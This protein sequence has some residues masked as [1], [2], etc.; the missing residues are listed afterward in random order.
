MTVQTKTVTAEELLNMPDDGTRRE[1]VRGELRET[2]PAGD[3]H[4][5]LALEIAAELRNHVKANKLGRTYT[6]ETGFKISSDPD[7]VRAPDAAFVGQ[8]RVEAA[9][10]ISGFRSG[11]PDLVVEVVSPNDRSSEVLDKA[12]DWLEA[13]CRMVLV[14][15]PERRAITVYRSREDIRVLTADAGDVVD[16]ADVVPGW[17]LSLPEI[18]AQE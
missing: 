7:T 6:A 5:Y 9:G 15:H 18:F 12:L 8:E 14:A 2:T 11:A 16:G 13:G 1:L 10:R 4:G 3:E 17:K